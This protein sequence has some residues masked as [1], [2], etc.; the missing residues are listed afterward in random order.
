MINLLFFAAYGLLTALAAVSAINLFAFLSPFADPAQNLIAIIVCAVTL[1]LS[2]ALTVFLFA[3]H[4]FKCSEKAGKRAFVLHGI[5][6]FAV[7]FAGLAA[8]SY[9]FEFFA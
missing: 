2:S 8:W 5:S 7:F 3:T 9:L 6:G 1:L 4:Y